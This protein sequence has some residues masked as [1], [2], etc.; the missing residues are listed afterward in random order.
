LIL[1][2]R[3]ALVILL[4]GWLVLKGIIPAWNEVYSDFA[5]YYVSARLFL[6]GADLSKLYDNTW[7]AD[8]IRNYGIET[9][10]KFS[11]FPPLTSLVMLPLSWLEPV[12]AMRSWIVIKLLFCVAF[13]ALTRKLTAWHWSSCALILLALGNNLANDFRNG[14]VYLPLAASLLWILIQS[15]QDRNRAAGILL[16]FLSWLK[17]LPATIIAGMFI[18]KNMRIAVISLASIVLF[19]IFQFIIFGWGIMEEYFLHVLL[20]HLDGEISGQ[21]SYSLLFQS[22]DGFF[23]HLF[24]YSAQFNPYPFIDFEAGYVI[25][26]SFVFA[27]VLVVL[28]LSVR[29]IKKL[30]VDGIQKKRL[31]LAHLLLSALV[32]LPASASYH[33]VL[34]SIPMILLLS[35]D[36]Y[37][38]NE[39]I[40]IAVIYVMIGIIPYGRFFELAGQAGLIFAY[41]R[42]WLISFLYFGCSWIVLRQRTTAVEA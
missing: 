38:R 29:R 3:Y 36:F 33:F 32:L 9:P 27:A 16:G 35:L 24:V 1:I 6:E 25:A 37:D 42:L 5:N 22:W 39:K 14:Q 15:E 31:I 41:P 17:Y 28:L 4:L 34:L 40:L 12:E 10:G 30:P 18:G 23:L 19:A 7:F 11:P 20:P 8:Q 2:V 26:K 13:V 21:S